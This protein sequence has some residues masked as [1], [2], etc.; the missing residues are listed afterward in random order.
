MG[1]GWFITG[2]IWALALFTVLEWK[3]CYGCW[4]QERISLLRIKASLDNPPSLSSWR[5]AKGTNSSDCCLWDGV[6]CNPTTGKVADLLFYYPAKPDINASLFLPFQEL[7]RLTLQGVHIIGCIQNQGWPN[8][9]S[10]VIYSS[11]ISCT[12][13]LETVAAAMN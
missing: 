7:R 3:I 5:S 4:E 10:L 2:F 1:Y 6:G 12:N 8:L 13:S 11:S 9:E